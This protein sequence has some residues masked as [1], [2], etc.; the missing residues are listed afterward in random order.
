MR[1]LPCLENPGNPAMSPHTKGK[2]GTCHTVEIREGGG[3]NNLETMLEGRTAIQW[4][5]NAKTVHNTLKIFRHPTLLL[6]CN[7]MVVRRITRTI[8]ITWPAKSRNFSKAII[9]LQQISMLNNVKDTCWWCK[10]AIEMQVC[11][12]S[13]GFL[14]LK[15]D[16]IMPQLWNNF[17]FCS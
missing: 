10:E 4:T 7:A 12:L 17:Y 13:M 11:K 3:G 8:I 1:Q 14:K 6:C 9:C 15:F 2:K 5:Q 16:R